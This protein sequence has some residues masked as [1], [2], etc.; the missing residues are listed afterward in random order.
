MWMLAISCTLNICNGFSYAQEKKMSELNGVRLFLT[1]AKLKQRI[2]DPTPFADYITALEKATTAFWATSE[3]PKAK[4][5]L[6]VVGVKPDKKVK[7]WCEAVDG[8]IPEDTL[9]KLE[10]KLSEVTPVA[11][12]QGPIAFALDMKLAGQKPEKFPEMPKKWAAGA[13]K[14]KEPLLIPDGLFKVIWPD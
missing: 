12:K 6:I 11:V 1:D 7:V 3:K 13:E 8:D 5:L 9:T 14:S 4:G 2:G 10:T